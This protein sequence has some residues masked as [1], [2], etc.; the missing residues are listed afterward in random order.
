LAVFLGFIPPFFIGGYF[1]GFCGDFWPI[2]VEISITACS[3]YLGKDIGANL[4]NDGERGEKRVVIRG[5]GADSYGGSP[6]D[7]GGVRNDI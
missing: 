1:W 5:D 2:K 6:R 7:R 4:Y 3:S